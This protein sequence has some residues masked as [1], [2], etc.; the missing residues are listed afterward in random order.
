MKEARKS[1]LLQLEVIGT[2][3]TTVF[4]TTIS[5]AYRPGAT[6]KFS[7]VHFLKRNFITFSTSGLDD[8]PVFHS[9]RW[10]LETDDSASDT[11][12]GTSRC[13][14]RIEWPTGLPPHTEAR[15]ARAPGKNSSRCNAG[16]M[17]IASNLEL[18]ICDVK[19]PGPWANAIEGLMNRQLFKMG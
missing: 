3:C 4:V 9:M 8:V 17:M 7:K 18:D 1:G 2:T 11:D 12:C 10:T 6:L 19:E 14:R 5:Q 13:T 15:L 16:E